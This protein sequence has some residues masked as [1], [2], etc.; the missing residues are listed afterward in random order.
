MFFWQAKALAHNFFSY[1]PWGADFYYLAQKYASKSLPI[2]ERKLRATFDIES[3]H[4]VNFKKFGSS[5]IE[6]A[7]FMQFGAGWT[8][9][10]PLTF[11]LQGVNHQ[12]LFDL[13]KWVKPVFINDVISRLS[14]GEFTYQSKRAK[15]KLVSSNAKEAMHQ[16]KQFYGIEYR[17]PV[18]VRESGMGAGSVDYISSTSTLEH[19]PEEDIL[20]I[21]LECSRILKPEG[22]VSFCVD[23]LDHYIK[24]GDPR[25]R[26]NYLKYSDAEW[27]KYNPPFH[28]QNRLRHVDYLRLYR[29]AGFDV[30][31]DEKNCADDATKQALAA[32]EKHEKFSKYSL[33]DLSV[34]SAITVLR[35]RQN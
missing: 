6:T 33:D 35:K 19:I 11:Y 22:V 8:M 26:Y 29:I 18:D 1:M 10:G 5:P 27:K 15:L 20:K 13:H 3:C 25:T 7:Q 32:I 28:F 2:S 12:T 31:S 4:I 23:Y 17:A 21:L 9:A 34:S 16:L 30:M 14:M 24:E